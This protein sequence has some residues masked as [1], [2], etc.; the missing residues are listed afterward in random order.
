MLLMGKSTISTGPFSIANC[1][2]L[3]EG[4]QDF[5]EP[6]GL[7]PFFQFLYRPGAGWMHLT[8]GLVE[9]GSLLLA[10]RW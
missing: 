7:P 6:H 5:E 4:N 8:P 9:V 1:K 10:G 2:R 3:P